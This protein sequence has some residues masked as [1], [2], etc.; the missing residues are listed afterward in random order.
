M[1]I[2]CWPMNYDAEGQNIQTNS[3]YST[4]LLKQK[5]LHL[6]IF[7]NINKLSKQNMWFYCCR[8]K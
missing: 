4:L 8:V 5:S 7:F 2:F 1:N 6:G 3:Y